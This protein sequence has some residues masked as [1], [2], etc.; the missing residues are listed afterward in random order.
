M[1][2]PESKYCT[3]YLHALSLPLRQSAPDEREGVEKSVPTIQQVTICDYS[4][5]FF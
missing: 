3:M 1:Q 4:H 2:M 5:T